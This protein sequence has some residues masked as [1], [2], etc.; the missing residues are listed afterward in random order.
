M[1]SGFAGALELS[2]ALEPRPVAPGDE[3]VFDE[4]RLLVERFPSKALVAYDNLEWLKA[5]KIPSYGVG[6][7]IKWLELQG[8]DVAEFKEKYRPV[9]PP[10]GLPL[11]KRPGATLGYMLDISR[12]K[13]PTMETLRL[14]VDLLA[15]CGY[16][17]FQLYTEHT[18]AYVGHETVW[19]GW[20]PM[21][22]AEI[23]EL[24][25]YCWNRGI[26]LVP[27]QNSFGHLGRWLGHKAYRHLAAA[28]EGFSIRH[29]KVTSKCG[30][31]LNPGAA[32]TYEFLSGL[33]DELLPNFAHAAEINV[34]CD[35]VWDIFAGNARCAER[36]NAVG[37]PTVYMEHVLKVR[38]LV[39]SRGKR[40][41]FWGDMVLRYP[42][43]L[44]RVPKDVNVLQWGYGGGVS[45]PEYACEFE[46]KCIALRRRGI[47]FTVC[48]STHTWK[49]KPYAFR[50]SRGNI[51]IASDAGRK[52]GAMGLLL[53]EWGDHGHCNPLLASVPAI[54]YAGLVCRGE[55][56]DEGALAD[57]IDRVLGCKVGKGL[58]AWG[59]VDMPVENVNDSGAPSWVMNGLRQLKLN[60][61]IVEMKAAGER[62][63]ES[64][65]AE[66]RELWLEVNRPGGLEASIEMFVK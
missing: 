2:A 45:N 30:C 52:Y 3:V 11:L 26:R 64:V 5:G 13:V 29:P 37:V 31:A 62:P 49:Y 22:A 14:F 35:E 51:D 17:E 55:P 53:T 59:L 61:R 6:N 25:A 39:A 27:N 47:P 41:A 63:A 44:D 46:G 56:S 28:P 48:P 4:G 58:V 20:S 36:A 9:E 34:G 10:L 38:D 60:R 8:V 7:V 66:Y 15:A 54:A 43:L 19:K 1:F 16:N 57:E 23:R 18:F 32:S 40:M 21:T 50:E 42:E 24:D 65:I 33:Y 12:D